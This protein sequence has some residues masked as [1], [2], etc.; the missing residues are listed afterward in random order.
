MFLMRRVGQR[1]TWALCLLAWAQSGWAQKYTFRLYGHA[2]GL[3]NLTANEFLRDRAGCLWIATEGGLYRY[4]GTSMREI[5]RAEGVASSFVHKIFEDSN[6]VVFISSAAGLQRWTGSRMVTVTYAGKPLEVM[7]H[8]TLAQGAPGE[9]LAVTHQAIFRLRSPDNGRTYSV[10]P[11]LEANDKRLPR[12]ANPKDA[13]FWSVL[14]DREGTVWFGFGQALCR[15]QRNRLTIL[16]E[17]NGITSDQWNTLFEDHA[18][19]LWITGAKHMAAL[20]KGA[21]R[22][23]GRDL[24]P[25]IKTV[26]FHRNMA[27][28]QQGR[29]LSCFG[30]GIARWENGHW[31]IFDAGTGWGHHSVQ[32][33][34]V[35]QEGIVWLGISGHGVAKWL[36]YNHWEHWTTTEGLASDEVWAILKDQAGQIWVADAAGVSLRRKPDQPFVRLPAFSATAQ[37]VANMVQ[38]TDGAIWMH[39]R[40]S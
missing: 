1:I 17:R 5:T 20:E 19:T 31:R 13:A 8:T 28:D 16:D 26:L 24:P 29:V 7:T 21:A 18:G 3:E 2:E 14:M 11:L 6:G 15:W 23:V 36:G 32:D 22:F 27:E 39:D 37:G 33:V 10:E 35:D 12:P 40:H 9:V 4:S 30:L 25:G 38:T 34:K